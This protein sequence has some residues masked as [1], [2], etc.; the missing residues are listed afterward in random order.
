M[1]EM[2]EYFMDNPQIIVNGFVRAGIAGALDGL[3]EQ[4]GKESDEYE[5][6]TDEEYETESDYEESNVIEITDEL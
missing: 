4:E 6:D 5:T 1:V 2:A 3:D